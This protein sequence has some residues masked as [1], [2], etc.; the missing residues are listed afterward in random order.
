MWQN[1]QDPSL[2]SHPFL[3]S[4]PSGKLSSTARL[5]SHSATSF[6]IQG[7]FYFPPHGLRP[8][9]KSSASLC[10]AGIRLKKSLSWTGNVDGGSA[11]NT[12]VCVCVWGCGRSSREQSISHLSVNPNLFGQERR[13]VFLCVH[14]WVGQVQTPAFRAAQDCLKCVCVWERKRGL[15][16][17]KKCI[18]NNTFLDQICCINIKK[19]LP[20]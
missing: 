3:T 13:A 4:T 14:T 12:G 9:R 16:V 19:M 5:E 8:R 6:Q 15:K 1:L 18:K 7:H 11:S 17:K 20:F 2:P 10:R